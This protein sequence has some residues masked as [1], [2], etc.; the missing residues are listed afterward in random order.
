MDF[1]KMSAET[2]LRFLFYTCGSTTY[3]FLPL[4]LTV[5]R[6]IN[7]MSQNHPNMLYI[8]L[9]KFGMGLLSVFQFVSF[10]A[11]PIHFHNFEYC[12]QNNEWINMKFCTH[13]VNVI[14]EY[15]TG[16][17]LYFSISSCG[18]A[19]NVFLPL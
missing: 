5:L 1:I 15:V 2:F 16:A 10:V 7:E 19:T 6:V 9:A 18:G 11:P 4:L 13:V 12:A 3:V 17:M 8:Q 14:C